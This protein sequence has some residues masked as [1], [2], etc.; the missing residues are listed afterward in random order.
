MRPLTL[1]KTAGAA[2]A[3]A[4]VGGLATRPA[5]QSTWYRRLR[6]P[7]FQPPSA[8]FP[9][10]WNLLYSDIAAVSASTIDTLEARGDTGQARA[11]E[12]ALAVNLVLNAGWSWV[13]FNR[14]MLGPAA[15]VAGALAVSSADL[16][17]RAGAVNAPAGAALAPYPLWCAFATALST[18]IWQLNR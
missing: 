9:I 17:R 8:A 1:A 16:A 13:F 12:R 5:V 15:V 4:A 18:R 7:D 11:Y 3:A 6:K 10:V 2:F 14:R